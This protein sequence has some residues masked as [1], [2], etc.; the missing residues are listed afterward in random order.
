MIGRK[1][2]GSVNLGIRSRPEPAERLRE[3]GELETP[4]RNCVE[5]AVTR[6]GR[7]ATYV[8][9]GGRGQSVPGRLWVVTS[10]P[11]RV[12]FAP[13]PT[14]MFHVGNARS[15]LFNWVLARQSGGTMV[16]R[17]EDTDAAELCQGSWTG[18]RR[19][20]GQAAIGIW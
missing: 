17:I 6:T 20:A 13:S 14:G 1:L 11:V 7:V 18:L 19:F 16:L 2:P 8:Y 9:I 10:S 4:S 15:L 12:R 5:A 3:V